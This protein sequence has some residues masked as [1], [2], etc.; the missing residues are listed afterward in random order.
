MTRTT[1]KLSLH[2]SSFLTT[3]MGG[4]LNHNIRFNVHQAHI[5][6]GSL[7]ESGSESGTLC[8]RSRDLTTKPWVSNSR[9]ACVQQGNGQIVAK[10]NN[11]VKVVKCKLVG[12]NY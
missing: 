12:E 10:V 11:Q 8:P 5:R 3:P 6:G 9:A 1:F 2:S 4:R 7:V